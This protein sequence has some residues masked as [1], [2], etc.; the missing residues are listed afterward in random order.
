MD[1]LKS[2]VELFCRDELQFAKEQ[3][4]MHEVEK[5]RKGSNQNGENHPTNF[6]K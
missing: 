6:G 4:V 5:I 1:L 2:I 3:K